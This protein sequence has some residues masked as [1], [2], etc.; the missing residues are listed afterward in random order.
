MD[1][2]ASQDEQEERLLDV[3]NRYAGTFFTNSGSEYSPRG[4]DKKL[5]SALKKIKTWDSEGLAKIRKAVEELLETKEYLKEKYENALT[6]LE[7]DGMKAIWKRWHQNRRLLDQL[8]SNDPE[9]EEAEMEC[10][11]LRSLTRFL[12]KKSLAETPSTEEPAVEMEQAEEVEKPTEE[13]KEAVKSE[14][15][16]E[17]K[18]VEQE[19]K[20]AEAPKEE[21]EKLKEKGITEEEEE[22]L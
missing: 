4:R 14:I 18:I 9:A 1:P 8:D 2:S 11:V 19:E 16:R 21:I 3:L 6:L 5:E 17:D 22:E 20:E 13:A 10:I 12:K 7:K 15:P